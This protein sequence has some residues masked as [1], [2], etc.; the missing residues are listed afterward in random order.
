[1][2]DDRAYLARVRD[3]VDRILSYT[4]EGEEAFRRDSR[5]QD[6]VSA[7]FSYRTRS[8]RKRLNQE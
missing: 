6:A 7:N 3:A 4:G 1:M 8:L 2:K 5:T